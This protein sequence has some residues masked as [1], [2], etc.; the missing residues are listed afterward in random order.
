MRL[1]Y[2]SSLY[3]PNAVGGA[4]RVTESLAQAMA[5]RGHQVS[6]VTLCER[7]ESRSERRKG[8]KVVYTPI[9]NVYQPFVRPQPSILRV[10]WHGLDAFN[11][12][13]ARALGR[14]IDQEAPDLVHTHNIA[15]F[16]AAV[17]SQVWRRGLP[18]VHTM[19]DYYLW[20]V[21]SN[22]F[23]GGCNC[24]RACTPCSIL[25][26]PRRIAVRRLSAAVAVSRSV[27]EAHRTVLKDVPITR[28]IY[29]TGLTS[30]ES[31]WSFTSESTDRI[32]CGYLGRLNEAK[33]VEL[34][35]SEFQSFS[36][37]ND[38]ELIVGGTGTST[39]VRNLMNRFANS[40]IRFH[41][42]VDSEWFM[43]QIDLLIVPS[44]WNDPF[45]LVVLE[46][47]ARGVAVVAARR[48]GIPE[49]IEDGEN[50]A[51]FEPT[52][53]GDLARALNRAVHLAHSNSRRRIADSVRH[54]TVASMCDQYENLYREAQQAS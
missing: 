7:T 37:S 24:D 23:R 43:K 28:V 12:V 14:I 52:V 13:A 53:E 46:A 42:F 9:R 10:V 1:L 45:P 11:I 8:V 22:M 6:V 16:S 17:W 35:F 21:R 50:G 34:L 33:G 54:L 26:I 30:V 51:L 20:C 15:G 4:E 29:N 48:G 5:E 31:G 25:T 32:R 27:L 36:K 2:L 19:Y 41:G 47:L 44:L 18:C 38:C 39:Y 49:I 40:R 3:H